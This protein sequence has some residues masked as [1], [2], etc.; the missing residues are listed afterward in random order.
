MAKTPLKILLDT[1]QRRS[2]IQKLKSLKEQTKREWF[3]LF[4]KHQ[5]F[6]KELIYIKSINSSSP[7]EVARSEQNL[8]EANARA[9]ET[10]ARAAEAYVRFTEA[11]VRFTEANVRFT[12]ANARAKEEECVLL[13]CFLEE[14]LEH[15]TRKIDKKP[16]IFKRLKKMLMT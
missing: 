8:A 4:V 11:N 2:E 15:M 6:E 9:A 12:E 3:T 10:K 1:E 7:E 16:G 14:S 5:V 13:E